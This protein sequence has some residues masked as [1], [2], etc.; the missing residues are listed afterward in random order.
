M[1]CFIINYFDENPDQ[2]GGLINRLKL[3]YGA[4]C[5]IL[6][7][8]DGGA[9][10]CAFMGHNGDA[11]F[12][13]LK[14][15]NNG[16]AW[17]HRYLDYFLKNS[18][19]KYLIKIDPDTEVLSMAKNLPVEDC[20]FCRVRDVT[21]GNVLFRIP[22]GGALGFTRGIAERIVNEGYFLKDYYRSNVRFDNFNDLM[23]M[24]IASRYNVPMVD[25][26]DFC[27]GRRPAFNEASFYHK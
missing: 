7:I 26:P 27:C 2:I 4:D 15:P 19:E 8:G 24:D 5:Q 1:I 9:T 11:M 3:V 21:L 12:D 14:T 22:A 17:T 13:H 18:T 23:L 6:M 16:G 20:V 10:S 25:R